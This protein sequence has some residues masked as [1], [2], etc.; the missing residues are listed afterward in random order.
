[1][2]ADRSRLRRAEGAMDGLCAGLGI[3]PRITDT[4]IIP[5]DDDGTAAAQF[6][7]GVDTGES[8][9]RRLMDAELALAMAR[10]EGWPPGW[11]DHGSTFVAP[12]R[13]DRIQWDYAE[14]R[15]RLLRNSEEAGCSDSTKPELYLDAL[16]ALRAYEALVKS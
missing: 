6:A 14:K 9:R 13:V 10:G 7:W 15:W 3:N 8:L 11:T 4:T 16:A 12:N 1:M 2:T 5:R